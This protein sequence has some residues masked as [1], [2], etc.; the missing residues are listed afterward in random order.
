VNKFFVETKNAYFFEDVEFWG[1]DKV[2]HI[3]FKEE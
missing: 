1:S 3:A 2:K